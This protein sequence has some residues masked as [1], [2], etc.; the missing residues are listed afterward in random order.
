LLVNHE[1][2]RPANLDGGHHLRVAS[3][4]VILLVA[5][6]VCSCASPYRPGT[7]GTSTVGTTG[8]VI[9]CVELGFR[10]TRRPEATGPVLVVSIGNRCDHA[11]VLD[12]SALRVSGRGGHDETIAMTAYDPRTELEPKWLG[13]RSWGEE[14]IEYHADP[15]GPP[16]LRFEVA[17]AGVVPDRTRRNG[18]AEVVVVPW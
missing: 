9:G 16:P 12:L 3:V 17:L 10:I 15:W 5:I 14:W 2:F 13:G 6:A 4:R 1:H 18:Q 8:R 7:I 11:T